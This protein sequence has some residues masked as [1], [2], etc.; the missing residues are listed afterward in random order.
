VSSKLSFENDGAVRLERAALP[1]LPSLV[2]LLADISANRAGVRIYDAPELARLLSCDS[3]LAATLAPCIGPMHRPV[4]AILFD[5]SER[6][7]WALGWHQDRTIAVREKCEV[8]GFGPWSIKAGVHHVEP[9]FEMI[10]KMVTVR[11]HLD[12][13]SSGNAPLM[14]VAGSHR[15]G[16]LRDNEIEKVVMQN[17]VF[18]CLAL[19][20]DVWVYSTPIIHAS[21]ASETLTRRRV[22]QVDYAAFELPEGLAWQGI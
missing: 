21:A 2:E 3:S 1:I 10:E 15:F 14:I 11:I 19:A 22:L 16:K 13:V 17:P 4:R 8:A 7:N 20:G 12:D 9:P 5:K 6:A 18:E